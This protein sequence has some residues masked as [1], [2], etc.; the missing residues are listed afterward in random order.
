VHRLPDQVP[1]QAPR[2]LPPGSHRRP[3]RPSA[4]RCT[5]LRTLLLRRSRACGRK[6]GCPPPNPPLCAVAGRCCQLPLLWAPGPVP[7]LRGLPASRADSA[8]SIPVTP[9]IP[10][11]RGLDAL[12]T[13]AGLAPRD[14][15]LRAAC[16]LRARSARGTL[17][18][19]RLQLPPGHLVKATSLRAA[20]GPASAPGSALADSPTARPGHMPAETRRSRPLFVTPA[21]PA[22]LAVFL[23]PPLSSS[24]PLRLGH[25]PCVAWRWLRQPRPGAHSQGFGAYWETD[26]TRTE[27]VFKIGYRSSPGS[28]L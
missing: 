4:Q 27:A 3:S 10:R 1:D 15:G 14:A 18:A 23:G 11:I 22:R 21:R 20:A 8:G 17:R 16:P 6:C 7:H 26:R 2:R 24:R 5:P 25:P 13:L 12:F 28:R 19:R 9:S